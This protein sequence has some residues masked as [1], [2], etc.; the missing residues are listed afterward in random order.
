LLS[1]PAFYRLAVELLV[2]FALVTVA[3]DAVVAPRLHAVAPG[4]FAPTVELEADGGVDSATDAVHLLVS[5][6]VVLPAL[7]WRLYRTDLGRVVVETVDSAR[8]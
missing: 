5:T 1:E 4:T 2:L 3:F 7:Y 6:V 8:R